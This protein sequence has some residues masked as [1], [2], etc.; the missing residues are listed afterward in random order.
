MYYMSYTYFCQ[1]KTAP[2]D[3]TPVNNRG[4]NVLRRYTP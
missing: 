4:G 1:F 2:A 3:R